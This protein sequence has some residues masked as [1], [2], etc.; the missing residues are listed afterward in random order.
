MEYEIEFGGDPQ[1]VTITLSGVAEV[2]DFLR[3][4]AALGGDARYR[5]GLVLLVD[6]TRLDT[7]HLTERDV[8]AATEPVGERD[9]ERPPLAV[10]IVAGDGRTVSDAR[11]W[12]APW[13]IPFPTPRFHH[14]RTSAR[15]AMQAA[16]RRVDVAFTTRGDVL[17][18]CL[19][20]AGRL[21]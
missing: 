18:A 13:R 3:L 6:V 21:P 7:T 10:A 20:T 16:C 9:W 11:L 12:R 2:V 8:A 15:L 4:N 14:D 1:D 17:P 5:R 19:A